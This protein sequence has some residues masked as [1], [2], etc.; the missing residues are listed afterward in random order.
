MLQLLLIAL[1]LQRLD[2]DTL[3][4]LEEGVDEG[5][6]S[7]STLITELFK[8]SCITSNLDLI[9]LLMREGGT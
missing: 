8:L 5:I 6:E 3:D 1:I 4:L 9:D 2:T 7:E